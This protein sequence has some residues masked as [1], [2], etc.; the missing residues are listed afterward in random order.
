MTDPPVVEPAAVDRLRRLGGAQLVRQ[1]LDLYLVQ[2]PKRIL[3]LLEGAD[4]GDADSVER[5]AH[6]LKSSAGNVGAL[7]LQQTA[8]GLEAAAG[9]GIVDHVMVERLVREYHESAAVLRGV[10]DRETA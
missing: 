10:L 9:A 1:M 6:T 4:A 5:A 7:R 2:G 8:E 3:T